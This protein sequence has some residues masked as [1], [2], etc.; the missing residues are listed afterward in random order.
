MIFLP[1]RLLQDR[2]VEIRLRRLDRDLL[3][4]ATGELRQKRIAGGPRVN[5]RRVAK[6]DVHRGSC[7]STP[8]SAR[9]S[10]SS[11]KT[12]RL[13][14]PGLHVGLVDLHDVRAGREQV[15]D[16]GVDRRRV[17]QGRQ[18]AAAAVVIDLRL[19]RHRERARHRHLD[20]PARVTLQECEVLDA[21]R[22]LAADGADDARHRIRDARCDRARCPGCRDRHLRAPSR[23]GWNSSRGESRRRSRCRCPASSCARIARMVASSCASASYGSGIRHSSRAR[24]RGGNRPASFCRSISQSGCGMLPTSVQ[25]K[26]SRTST[27]MLMP[28][29]RAGL[30]GRGVGPANACLAA[31]AERIAAPCSS[32]SGAAETTGRAL[33]VE[34]QRRTHG[35]SPALLRRLDRHDRGRG[36]APADP[37][38]TASMPLIGANGT[39]F[40][41]RRSVH[42]ARGRCAKELVELLAERLV[43]VDARKASAEARIPRK[44]LRFERGRQPESRTSRAMRDE[45]RSCARRRSAECTPARAADDPWTWASRRARRTRQTARR[46]NAPWPRASTT[47]TSLPLPVLRALEQ[48]AQDSVGRVDA[49]DG[50]GERR[51]QKPRT[52][53][54]HDDA[55]ES[56]QRLRHGVVA[57]SVDVRAARCQSR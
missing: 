29:P 53:R 15:A 32:S 12:P 5:D 49:R 21:H 42:S 51:P 10:A 56:G 36:D 23:S 13:V 48:R 14:R 22:V 16:L 4:P 52:F 19:L 38:T 35:L 41:F 1:V 57:R 33:A 44:M 34:L 26:R 47:S 46:R 7:P 27:D 11:P 54:I 2:A 9:F 37:S 31:S 17:V 43:V 3:A 24:T 28:P 6:A 55:Q 45:S 18:L 8:S 39:S 20:A 50:I 25:G 40:A 30:F